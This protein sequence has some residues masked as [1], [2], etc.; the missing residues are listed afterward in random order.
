VERAPASPGYRFGAF[1]IDP[2]A[3]ELRKHG[4]R[5]K[6]Q[7]QPFQVLVMLLERPGEVV[8]REELRQKLWP[9]DTFVDFDHGLNSAINKL[10]EALGDSADAPRF[11]E[12]LPRRG[13]RFTGVVE[14]L[15]QPVVAGVVAGESHQ[16][17]AA[18]PYA[19]PQARPGMRW[20]LALGVLAV[21]AVVSYFVWKRS[22]T[23]VRVQAGKVVLAVLPFDNLSKDPEQEYFSDGFTDEMI[24]Q[25]G[26]LQPARLGVIARGSAMRYKHTDKALPQI[27]Q[28]LG[29]GYVLEGAVLR[30]GDRVRITAALIQTADQTQLWSKTYERDLKDILSVQSDVAGAIAREIEVKLSSEQSQALASPP[31]VNP[32]AYEAYLKGQ[33]FYNRST[34]QGWTEAFRY[35]EQ[36]VEKDPT[37]ALAYANLAMA[38][39]SIAGQPRAPK[40]VMPKAKAA[41]LRAVQLDNN[42]GEAHAALGFVNLYYDWDWQAAQREY[43]R[44]FELNPKYVLLRLPNSFFLAAQGKAD[45]SL[46]E[47]HEAQALDPINIGLRCSEGRLLYYAHRYD[48]AISRYQR[49]LELEPAYLS[50]CAW[51]GLA[52]LKKGM[53]D[54]AIAELRKADIPDAH[55][56]LPI[57][58]LSAAYYLSGRKADG[59]QRLERL[60]ALKRNRFV[61][62]YDIAV[63]YAAIGDRKQTLDWLDKAIE[64]R[65]GLVVYLRV[66]PIW[67]S[68]RD[69]PRFEKIVKQV[70]IPQ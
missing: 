37:F 25:L 3:G 58:A 34:G 67:D 40:E 45:E 21:I 66:D 54:A 56:T 30:A 8:T 10:R 20:V 26:S 7:D 35:Y 5:I 64:E 19:A 53:Y 24:A 1:E 42:L 52:Y 47:V 62:S 32:E 23:P 48:E 6:L 51:L 59:L 14:P 49:A 70:G 65:A 9:A 11:I 22:A 46:R 16:E 55:S 33:Y 38:Y 50:N 60:L 36:A 31:T 17:P 2:R 61:S 63:F 13:Y 18:P 68:V 57:A 28:E 43:G 69:D 4:I 27:G 44:A 15:G 29:A 12:T 41:A 39:A